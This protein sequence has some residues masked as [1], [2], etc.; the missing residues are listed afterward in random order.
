[1]YGDQSQQSLDQPGMGANPARGQLNRKNASY[2]LGYEVVSLLRFYL[3]TSLSMDVG[4]VV[5]EGPSTYL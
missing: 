2:L 3:S 4:I 5:H 1:M